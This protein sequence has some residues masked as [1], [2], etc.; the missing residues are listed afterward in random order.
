[1]NKLNYKYETL[2]PFKICVLE[3]FPFL[4]ADFDALTNY[5]IMCKLAEYIN[6]VAKSQNIVQENIIELN[7]WFN[8][9]D[10][11]EEI[12]NKLDKMA[13]SGQLT[14]IVSQYL[15]ISGILAYNTIN[16]MKISDNLVN[17]SFVKTYGENTLLDGKGRFYKVRTIQNTDIVDEVNIIALNNPNLIAELIPDNNELITNLQNEIDTKLN[18]TNILKNKKTII[19]GD[20]L[21]LD[22]G[23]GNK[24]INISK[25]NGENYGNGSAG[26]LS[27][28]IT[29]PYQNMDFND[30]LDYIIANKTNEELSEIQY[31]IVGGGINDALNNYS[32]TNISAAVQTF[33]TKAKLNFINAKIII[34][35]L[36]TFKWLTSIQIERYSSIINTVKNNGLQTTD[37]FLF[38]TI[39]NREY[40]SGDQVHLTDTGYEFLANKVLCYINNGSINTYEEV[41]YTLSENWEIPRGYNFQILKKGNLV[42]VYGILKYNG[43]GI[44]GIIPI[45]DFA[46]GVYVTGGSTNSKYIP[47]LFYAT[48]NEAFSNLTVVNGKLE[49]GR[50]LNY[51]S[52]SNPYVYVNGTF[53]I[54]LN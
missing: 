25:C 15:Q 26:F 53:P 12:N 1:M 27:K 34:I 9:L 4:E 11:Q 8:N 13:E 39:D 47:A 36:H 44:S 20:S 22:G 49:T 14:E 7:N 32:P 16:D 51:S 48:G 6:K 21:S 31:L 24:F 38:W 2:T 30:M 42:E 5:Q 41:K 18:I 3:N 19:I 23:W 29:N 46:N 54:G 28:G 45:L 50:P 33:I 17:G 52:L 35:P 43:G 10:V 40:D 37:D